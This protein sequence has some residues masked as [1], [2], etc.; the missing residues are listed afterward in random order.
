MREYFLLI[1]FFSVFAAL[2]V[3]AFANK[4]GENGANK[5]LNQEKI[6]P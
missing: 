5:L 6:A 1:L 4:D 2:V 3:I